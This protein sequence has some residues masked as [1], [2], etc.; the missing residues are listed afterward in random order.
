MTTLTITRGL[1]ASGKTTWARARVEEAGGRVVRVNRDDARLNL[2]GARHKTRL[3]H[4]DEQALT[5][6][7]QN[8]VAEL[9]GIGRDVIVD[10]TNLVL[11]FARQWADL[12]RNM[13]AEF[14][15]N[16]DFLAVPVEECVRRNAARDDGVPERVIRE[17]HARFR[18]DRGL[19]P[20]RPTDPAQPI[21]WYAS[22]VPY[23]RPAPA[24]RRP[25]VWLV[26]IDGT[27]AD[28][29][30]CGREPYDWHRVGEDDPREGVVTLVRSLARTGLIVLMS[31]RDAVCRPQTEEWLNRHGIRRHALHMRPQGDNRSDYLVKAELFDKHIRH[32]Y[33]V[34]GAVDD[35]DQVVRYW[36]ALG[37]TCAQVAPGNF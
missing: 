5:R 28:M 19:P 9:L 7:Q 27:L 15:V 20:V 10:D 16:D 6:I 34:L 31:G 3:S 12:A 17:M 36:R 32:R 35:R 1:P 21:D 33:D 8:A 24:L 11:R 14:V 4:H 22:V 13:G 26:D 23:E 37:L 25:K 18:P 2:F 30:R 29:T